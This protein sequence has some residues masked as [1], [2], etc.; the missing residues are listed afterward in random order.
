MLK[1]TVKLLRSIVIISIEDSRRSNSAVDPE[2]R[3][4]DSNTS[5][6]SSTGSFRLV[7]TCSLDALVQAFMSSTCKSVQTE[8][9]D[10][11]IYIYTSQEGDYELLSAAL[12]SS[13]DKTMAISNI[14]ESLD[15]YPVDF[16]E[17]TMSIMN[18]LAHSSKK[19]LK[20]LGSLTRL[21][22]KRLSTDT[23]VCVLRVKQERLTLTV[24]VGA[25]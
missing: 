5:F 18:F 2:G 21:I 4:R 25:L 10:A 23:K 6:S 14:I 24:T 8:V 1:K 17:S 22:G 19:P 12:Y 16:T 7:R 11:L 15:Q 20:E 9:M 3:A 13:N